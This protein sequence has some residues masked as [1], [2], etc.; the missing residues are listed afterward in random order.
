[1]RV[2]ITGANG[3]LGRNLLFEFI[4]RHLPYPDSLELILLGRSNGH[5]SLRRRMRDILL[6][7]GR[8]YMGDAP[9]AA[10]LLSEYHQSRIRYVH[11][12][13]DRT[14]LGI[15]REGLRILRGGPIDRFFHVAALTDLRTSSVSARALRRTN[16]DGTR[17]VLDLASSLDV[18]E[19]SYVGSAYCCGDVAGRIAP[20]F[21]NRTGRFRNPYEEAK[22]DAELQVRRFAARTG[23]RCRY[24]RPSIVCGRLIEPVLGSIGKFGVF[25]SVAAFLV[26]MKRSLLPQGAC[27]YDSPLHVDLRIRWDPNAAL[28][29]VP[30]DYAA[31]VMYQV[32]AQDDP[33]ESYHIVNER[34]LP[35]RELEPF[36]MEALR[37]RGVRAVDGEPEDKN[38][39]EELYYKTVGALFTPYVTSG[40]MLFD[41]GSV[42]SAV[43]RVGLECPP[44]DEENLRI[45]FDYAA[46]HNFGMS[47]GRGAA[48]SREDQSACPRCPELRATA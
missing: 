1:M 30:G 17:K 27:L 47:A 21:I 24:F 12:D 6:H 42:Q 11:A 5:G 35:V 26:R 18:G 9:D 14:G 41:T 3:V 29:I 15:D 19:F 45:L 28:N 36:V 16:V 39:L 31:K 43:R 7:D 38:R 8:S 10:R 44:V 40:P 2:V 23:I 13:L 20:D 34:P 25:Y 4:K 37:V 48:C 33:G 32:C 22:L 46:A